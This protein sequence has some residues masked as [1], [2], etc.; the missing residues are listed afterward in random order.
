MYGRFGHSNAFLFF[1]NAG[2]LDAFPPSQPGMIFSSCAAVTTGVKL[3]D[4]NLKNVKNITI[5][6]CTYLEATSYLHNTVK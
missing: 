6:L 5:T 3:L 2:I 1:R 4:L